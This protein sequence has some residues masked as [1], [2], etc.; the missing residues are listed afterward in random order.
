MKTI[1]ATTLLSAL[2]RLSREKL[3][4]GKFGTARN[5]FRAHSS[6]ASFLEHQPKR[7]DELFSPEAA[8]AYSSFLEKR[9]CTPNTVSF[10][11]RILRAAWNRILDDEH[12]IGKILT[13]PFKD[14]YT[15][16][17]KTVNRAL[18]KDTIKR[19][20]EIDL[21][22]STKAGLTNQSFC[23]DLFLFSL[24]CRGMAFVDMAFLRMSDISGGY[25]TY[26]RKK[27]GQPLN[28]FL[29]PTI[30]RLID[31]WHESDSM[32]VFPI[33]KWTAI[34]KKKGEDTP[35]G[36]YKKYENA[37]RTYNRTLKEIGTKIGFPELSSY[38]SRHSW[39]CLAKDSGIPLGVISEGLGHNSERTTKIYLDSLD[40]TVI[41]SASRAILNGILV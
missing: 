10:Y 5:Y 34:E 18:P 24:Y 17:S 40:R 14:V 27:T 33:I 23:R 29:E 4:L 3:A 6:F 21:G 35:E 39:A 8:Y 25:I 30:N 9:N 22:E 38:N 12:V 36:C 37:L 1:T 7:K 15:G 28:I 20:R 31:R 26:R 16:I 11:L 13:D 41:D 2:E 32:Y 19:I